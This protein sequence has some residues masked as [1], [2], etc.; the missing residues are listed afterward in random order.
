MSNPY[1]Y[2]PQCTAPLALINQMED[3]G[4]KERLR[5]SGCGFT[6]W[7]NPTPVLAAIVEYQGQVLLARNAAWPGKMFAL[8]TGFMEAGDTPE[9]GIAREVKEETNLDCSEV[10]LV[11]VYD[12]QRMNQV[13]IAYHVVAHG[14]IQLSPELAEYRLYDYGDV[15]C[16]AAGTGYA[17]AQWLKSRGYAPQFVD[18]SKR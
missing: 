16:W 6:H 13:I 12:F 1:K 8:I 10:N 18:W 3:G 9:G 5:C 2:C 11:G 14:Q 15:K 4:P 17:L 7:N